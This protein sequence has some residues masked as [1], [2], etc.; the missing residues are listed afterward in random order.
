MLIL[1]T[2]NNFLQLFV[3]WEGVGLASYLLINFW[4]TRIQA[5]KSSIKA[6]LVNRVGDFFLSLAIF[7]IYLICD[8]LDFDIVFGL[9]PLLKDYN[10]ILGSFYFNILDL[11]C[12]FLFFGA[13]G[14][15]AQLGLHSWLPDAMEGPTPVSA[16]IHAA[17]MVT[18]GVFLNNRCSSLF[19]YSQNT[20]NFII[21]LGS[22]NNCLLCCHNRFISK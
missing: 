3:G 19:E 1:I 20:L 11:I 22:I 6:M 8:S 16:L 10:L 13:V 12:L 2:S 18:A 17:T 4:F 7:N 15:S 5:N 14:K 9:S 21:V